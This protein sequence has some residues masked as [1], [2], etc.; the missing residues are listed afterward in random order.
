M[1]RRLQ[2]FPRS[3]LLPPRLFAALHSDESLIIYFSSSSSSTFSSS[4]SLIPRNPRAFVF[5]LLPLIIRFGFLFFFFYLHDCGTVLLRGLVPGI[6]RERGWNARQ[7]HDLGSRPVHAGV[8]M[9]RSDWRGSWKRPKQRR[10]QRRRTR[11][12]SLRAMKRERKL[13]GGATES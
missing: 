10:E 5:T 2:N 11:E 1:S 4:F 3:T 7:E 6:R 8:I 12:G 13:R 9:P